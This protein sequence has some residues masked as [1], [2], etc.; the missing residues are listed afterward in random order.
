MAVFPPLARA[1]VPSLSG[2]LM[3]LRM[4][5]P[6]TAP[7]LLWTSHACS[8][9]HMRTARI[10]PVSFRYRAC[11]LSLPRA[12]PFAPARV[13]FRSRVRALSLPRVCPFAPAR[14]SFRSRA[15]ALS[16]PRP[17]PLPPAP[18]FFRSRV[19]V[20]SLPRPCP[21]LWQPCSRASVLVFCCLVPE[22]SQFRQD[23]L[24]LHR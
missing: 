21:S 6:P 12:C 19:R 16:L 10:T 14:V 2:A 3:S 24:K 8:H 7:V 22:P 1:L 5:S 15:C 11:V 9:I 18:L 20:L 13:S 17:C 23:E 4:C